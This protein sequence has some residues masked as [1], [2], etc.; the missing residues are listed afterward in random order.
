MVARIL[1]AAVMVVVATSCGPDRVAVE[2]LLVPDD[3]SDE[4]FEGSFEVR[5]DLE[6]SDIRRDVDFDEG[7]DERILLLP[8]DVDPD[9]IFTFYAA[10][11]DEYSMDGEPYVAS[12]HSRVTWRNGDQ[13]IVVAVV[14]ASAT[15]DDPI[16]FLTLFA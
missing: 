6:I 1:V 12:H 5:L 8:D 16:I 11:F 10:E 13:R 14:D 4:P 9:E 2:D 15:P 7:P 3:A